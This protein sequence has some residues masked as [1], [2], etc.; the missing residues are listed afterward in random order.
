L[1]EEVVLDRIATELA[2]PTIVG[3]VRISEIDRRKLSEI[4]KTINALARS[5]NRDQV[6]EGKW[7]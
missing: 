3:C 6:L 2:P 7:K 5:I 4:E 1:V